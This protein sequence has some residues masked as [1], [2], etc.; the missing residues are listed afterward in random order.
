VSDLAWRARNNPRELLADPEFVL[1]LVAEPGQIEEIGYE[2]LAKLV[3]FPEAPAALV[4]GAIGSFES[5]KRAELADALLANPNLTQPQAERLESAFDPAADRNEALRFH[6]KLSPEEP[7]EAAHYLGKAVVG[8]FREF[9]GHSLYER[10]D[11][12]NGFVPRTL[13]KHR[14]DDLVAL[15]WIID[16]PLTPDGLL[17]YPHL[18]PGYAP[19]REALTRNGAALGERLLAAFP[20]ERGS[21]QIAARPN[22]P[23]ELVARLLES[24]DELVVYQLATNPRLTPA[25]QRVLFDRGEPRIWQGL[26]ANPNLTQRMELFLAGLDDAKVSGTLLQRP[27][28]QPATI[29]ELK[30]SDWQRVSKAANAYRPRSKRGHPRGN[31]PELLDRVMAPYHYFMERLLLATSSNADE[32]LLEVL[33]DSTDAFVRLAVATHPNSSRATKRR[34]AEDTDVRVARAAVGEA[35]SVF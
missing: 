4:R 26:A 13:L 3:R 17:A 2:T 24:T 22:L 6:A 34:L 30:Q 32:A 12:R 16:F 23:E 1:R 14:P 29:G 18:G 33:A 21:K 8:H 19:L 5:S 27:Y 28:L 20:S 15:R 35:T 7:R 25:Q 9:E 11:L 10:T 31:R